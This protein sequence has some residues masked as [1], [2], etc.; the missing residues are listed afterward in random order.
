MEACSALKMSPWKFL[1]ELKARNLY[2][3]VGLE[4]FLDSSELS[5]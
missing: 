2:L 1:D 3:N 4:D 5:R